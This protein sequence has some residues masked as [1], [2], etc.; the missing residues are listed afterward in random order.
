[1]DSG[2]GLQP[3]R[4]DFNE[5]GNIVGDERT[6]DL[7][8]SDRGANRIYC[9]DTNNVLTAIAGNGTISGGGVVFPPCRPA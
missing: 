2:G 3:L 4:N 9:L 1:M 6:S 7:Y 5:L 8:V